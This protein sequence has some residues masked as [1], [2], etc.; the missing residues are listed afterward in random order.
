[1]G[2]V[3]WYCAVYILQC[4][5]IL[6][7]MRFSV[8]NVLVFIFTVLLS[9]DIVILE[10]LLT[11]SNKKK[12][13]LATKPG[14]TLFFLKMSI[15]TSV[16]WQLLWYFPFLCKCARFFFCCSSMYLLFRSFPFIWCVTLGFGWWPGFVFDEWLLNSGILLLPLL[17]ALW[18]FYVFY[19]E[20]SS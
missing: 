9:H 7:S 11:L 20:W 5:I 17:Y 18:K 15:T 12:A 8:L 4:T 6:F 3:R 10:V 1:M 14:S 19:L 16:L 13:K 2:S